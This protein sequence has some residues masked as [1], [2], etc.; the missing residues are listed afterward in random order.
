M[1]PRGLL[2][3]VLLLSACGTDSRTT[4]EGEQGSSWPPAETSAEPDQYGVL[5]DSS[6]EGLRYICGDHFGI[7]DAA[8]G[9]G[10]IEGEVVQF[11]VGD[12]KL[13]AAVEPGDRL[14]PYDLAQGAPKVALNIARFLQTLDDDGDGSNGIQIIESV[15]AH[16]VGR[17]LDFTGEDWDATGTAVQ[18]FVTDLTF[19][20]AAGAR[21]L[22]SS[23][24]AYSHFATTLDAT[25]VSQTDEIERLAGEMSCQ[26][27]D[28]CQVVGL[29][30]MDLGYCPGLGPDIAVTSSGLSDEAIQGA[31]SQREALIEI[32]RQVRSA[33]GVDDDVHG[34]C[35][36]MVGPP[37]GDDATS[38]GGAQSNTEFL[39]RRFRRKHLLV[40]RNL[41]ARISTP[42]PAI[43]HLFGMVSGVPCCDL[44]IVKS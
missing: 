38:P 6:V 42:G 20:T 26:T 44:V 35:W 16:A 24:S 13:G 41:S 22:V 34:S 7:T 11:L 37:P 25:I 40:G 4:A 18:Q 14:T 27:S 12:I 23:V 28:D 5:V 1:Y 29:V 19:V 33:A 36:I 2:L 43:I 8:G 32:N 10:Y 30:T 9:F 15:H 21:E 39:S 17:V 31:I 3:F